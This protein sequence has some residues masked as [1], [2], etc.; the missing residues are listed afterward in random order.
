MEEWREA[1]SQPSA[2]TLLSPVVGNQQRT[3][4][5]TSILCTL[6]ITQVLPGGN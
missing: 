2:V 6:F 5:V 1:I 3:R 4:K